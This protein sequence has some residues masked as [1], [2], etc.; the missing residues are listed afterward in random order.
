MKHL[1]EETNT[2]SDCTAL[3]SVFEF[4]VWVSPLSL[5]LVTHFILFFAMM[6]MIAVLQCI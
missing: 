4:F 3:L 2:V 1:L 5:L 6:P